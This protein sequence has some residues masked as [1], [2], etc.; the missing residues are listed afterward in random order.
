MN[1]LLS[2]E[3]D[4]NDPTAEQI[5]LAEDIA[6]IKPVLEELRTTRTPILTQIQTYYVLLPLFDQERRQKEWEAGEFFHIPWGNGQILINL[7][8]TMTLEEHPEDPN[9]S[10]RGFL[11]RID[12]AMPEL[13]IRRVTDA[14][15][16]SAGW[17]MRLERDLRNFD[18][19][20]QPDDQVTRLL[21]EGVPQPVM[22]RID[23]PRFLDAAK[24]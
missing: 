21:L 1:G 19:R 15:L 20:L 8:W 13:G 11:T 10:F 6:K 16:V 17:E 9:V 22:R 14:V 3:A 24:Q 23:V 12:N 5:I 7:A 18:D 2:S 4:Y